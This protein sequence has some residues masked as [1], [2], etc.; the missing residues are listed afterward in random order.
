[1]RK[2]QLVYGM[3][4]GHMKGTEAPQPSVSYLPE[5]ESPSLWAGD[6]RHIRVPG[7]D[8]KNCPADLYTREQSSM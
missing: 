6:Y 5:A 8:P 1:M 7:S 4:R 2:P 3:M